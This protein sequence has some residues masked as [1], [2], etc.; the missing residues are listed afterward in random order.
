MIANTNRIFAFK[1]A[2]GFKMKSQQIH[3]GLLSPLRDGAVITRACAGFCLLLK[4]GAS[5][6]PLLNVLPA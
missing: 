4:L 6:C 5:T 1:P 3:S 2:Y